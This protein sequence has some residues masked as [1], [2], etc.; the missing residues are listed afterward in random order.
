MTMPGFTAE[1]SL[2]G[3]SRRYRT[4]ATPVSSDRIIPAGPGDPPQIKLSYQRPSI[5]GFPGLLTITG[6]NFAAD[7]DVALTLSNCA[8]GG[9]SCRSSAHTSK[10]FNY[11][12]HPWSCHRYLGGEFNTT[13]PI[14]C[15]GDT[16]VTVQ[17]PFGPPVA[18]GTTGIPC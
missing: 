12:T 17:Y 9:I 5:P 10:P 11:C 8:E 16:T 4:H 2:N 1:A 18:T 13:V 6:Q 15:G 14:L 3:V 7:V